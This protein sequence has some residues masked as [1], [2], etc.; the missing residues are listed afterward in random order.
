MACPHVG[1]LGGAGSGPIV[2]VQGSP[3]SAL[4]WTFTSLSSLTD[5]IDFSNDN[6]ATWTF[7]PT[8]PYDAAV[9][10]I[11]LN[12]KGTMAAASGGLNPFFELRFRVRVK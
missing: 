8:P 10:R 9:N 3:S 1:D 6:G 2:F 11:R 5:D 12:P 4:T 7:V